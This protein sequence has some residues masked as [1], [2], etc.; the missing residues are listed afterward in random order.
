M[1]S[2]RMSATTESSQFTERWLPTG[3]VIEVIRQ[4][5]GDFGEIYEILNT[6]LYN[7]ASEVIYG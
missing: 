5:S 1:D 7:R 4:N 6:M 3:D 2:K